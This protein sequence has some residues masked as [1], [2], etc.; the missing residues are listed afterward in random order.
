MI[1]DINRALK[2]RRIG[3]IKII[4]PERY[5]LERRDATLNPQQASEIIHHIYELRLTIDLD[6]KIEGLAVEIANSLK[7]FSWEFFYLIPA[8]GLYKLKKHLENV[9]DCQESQSQTEIDQNDTEDGKIELMT[10]SAPNLSRKNTR[11][12]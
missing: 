4:L 8:Y 11:F 7:L 12:C 3:E 2:P 10:V 9:L 5:A 6:A 1:V